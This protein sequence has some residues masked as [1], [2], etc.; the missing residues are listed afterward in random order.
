[1]SSMVVDFAEN[2]LHQAHGVRMVGRVKVSFNIGLGRYPMDMQCYEQDRTEMK[3]ELMICALYTNL[4]ILRATHML[5]SPLFLTQLLLHSLLRAR[6]QLIVA[7][8][9][10]PMANQYAFYD[11]QNAVESIAAPMCTESDRVVVVG[12]ITRACVHDI[13][14]L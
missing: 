8:P 10:D 3:Y 7:P 9:F 6:F 5:R 13:R 2:R 14:R 11:A 1:M 4:T 12:R